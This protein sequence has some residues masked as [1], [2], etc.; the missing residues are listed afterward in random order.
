M[1]KPHLPLSTHHL[2]FFFTCLL[3]L[4]IIEL[5]LRGQLVNYIHPSTNLLTLAGGLLLLFICLGL[6]F[7]RH[8]L[9]THISTSQLA[10]FALAILCLVTLKAT[11]LSSTM[12]Q[13]RP[14]DQ[15]SPIASR[16]EVNLNKLTEHFSLIEWHHAWESDPTHQFYLHK[17]V[18]A[19]GF[20][21]HQSDKTYL[22]RLMLTCCVV[23]ARPVQIEIQA[24]ADL[25]Q[26]LPAEGQWLEVKGRMIGDQRPI[27]E[28]SEFQLIDQ[29]SNPYLY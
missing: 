10:F 15:A 20:I 12:A 19:I 21:M 4:G 13:K 14:Q 17:P 16:T 9:H 25:A 23:D 28:V 27:I 8:P 1:T 11:P 18:Q 6:I 7:N 2:L 24:A 26:A 22:T 29:P 5:W 3:G